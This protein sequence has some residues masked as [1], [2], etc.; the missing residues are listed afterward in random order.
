MSALDLSPNTPLVADG[1][2]IHKIM[3]SFFLYSDETKVLL[4]RRTTPMKPVHI[5]KGSVPLM[6]VPTV[7]RIPY[8]RALWLYFSA[9]CPVRI[10]YLDGNSSNV[11]LANLSAPIGKTK[12]RKPPLRALPKQTQHYMRKLFNYHSK[13]GYLMDAETGEKKCYVNKGSKYVT[14]PR[15][16][17]M[18]A[19]RAVWLYHYDAL[20]EGRIQFKDGNPLNCCVDNLLFEGKS[21]QERAT[22]REVGHSYLWGK[23]ATYYERTGKWRARVKD[24]HIGYYDTE[25]EAQ[26]AAGE[27]IESLKTA[28]LL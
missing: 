7:G 22:D 5:T 25:E 10:K 13:H 12:P 14:L 24:K 1:E 3:K 2:R 15:G 9:E 8:A 23:H 6:S 19:A 20:P 26:T 27:Y 17:I 4:D 21:L 11:T 28:P 16:Q 18:T